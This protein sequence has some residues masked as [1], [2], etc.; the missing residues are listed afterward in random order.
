[1][2]ELADKAESL[3]IQVALLEDPET[4]LERVL[5]SGQETDAQRQVR[6]ILQQECQ[7]IIIR[8]RITAHRTALI[9]HQRPPQPPPQ[10][11][12]PND[13]QIPRLI[14]LIKL[15]PLINLLILLLQVM[16]VGTVSVDL[17]VPQLQFF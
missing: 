15:P 3:E 14:L 4:V 1:M 10:S 5:R 11:Q 16:D 9:P 2:S 17:S 13:P 6:E 8:P 7:R 12:I